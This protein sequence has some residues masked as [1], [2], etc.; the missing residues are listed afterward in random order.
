MCVVPV[1]KNYV[2]KTNEVHLLHNVGVST[3]P[4]SRWRDLHITEE[5]RGHRA[6]KSI[7]AVLLMLCCLR[8][9]VICP[10]GFGPAR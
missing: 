6:A 1:E 2:C 10:Q 7:T 4:V 9:S 3:S 5:F 8:R